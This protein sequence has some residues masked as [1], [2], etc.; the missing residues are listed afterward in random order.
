MEA[1][2][3]SWPISSCPVTL[4][5]TGSS[6]SRKTVLEWVHDICL[7][8]TVM[9]VMADSRRCIGYK[10]IRFINGNSLFFT[11]GIFYRYECCLFKFC[12]VFVYVLFKESTVHIFVLKANWKITLSKNNK[13]IVSWHWWLGWVPPTHGTWGDVEQTTLLTGWQVVACWHV[14]DAWW[15]PVYPVCRDHPMHHRCAASPGPRRISLTRA[16]W[17]C[18]NQPPNTHT[19]H[20][21]PPT[22]N[23]GRGESPAEP[24]RPL[25]PHTT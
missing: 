7:Q 14:G 23:W 25:Q 24:P 3:G 13:E 22:A 2:I 15:W 18:L 5:T 11:S 10:L 8:P 20:T 12:F 17:G 9:V 4:G 1:L 19:P 16:R 21:V 6:T